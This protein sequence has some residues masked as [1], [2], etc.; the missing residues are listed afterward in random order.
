MTDDE[1]QMPFGAKTKIGAQAAQNVADIYES[2]DPRGE[3]PLKESYDRTVK[4]RDEADAE[5]SREHN[6]GIKKLKAG[7]KVAGKLATRG[8]GKAR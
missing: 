1:K 8:Y 5:V 6:R 4:A 2:I 3:V 7:G